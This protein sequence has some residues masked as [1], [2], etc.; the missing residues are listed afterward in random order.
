MSEA[1]QQTGQEGP[2]P[3]RKITAERYISADYMYAERDKLWARA[4][5]VAGVAQDVEEPGDFF[6]F[7]LEPE[8]IIV[9]RSEAGELKAFFNVCQHRGAKLIT[10][11]MGNMA[12]WTC[13]YHGWSFN[14]DGTLCNVPDADRFSRGTPED[15]LALKSLRVESWGGM[16]W[17][18]MD[19][20][21]PSL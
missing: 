11:D 3:Y 15:E 13:P 7:D 16:V 4:W 6:V 18:C 10:T 17:V 9:S 14:N 20:E 8:S 12:T 21:A 1:R 5:L 19:Q 2:V